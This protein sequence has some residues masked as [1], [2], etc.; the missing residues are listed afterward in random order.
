MYDYITGTIAEI[1]PAEAIIENNGIGY[2][3]QISLQTYSDI[4]QQKQVKLYIYNHVREDTHLWF[5]FATKDERTVFLQLIS[6]SGIGPNSARVMLSSLNAN[7]I[8]TAIIQGDVNKIKSVKGIGLKTAQKVIIELK[9][10]IGKTSDTDSITTLLPYNNSDREEALS[11]L[12][13]LGFQKGAAEKALASVLR[14]AP[15]L[16]LEELIKST[17]KIL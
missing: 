2:S 10:K 12:V 17:L 15:E 7:E 1:S 11:A 16:P 9:D 6:V 5:G 14:K 3:L 8:R 13:M 4:H